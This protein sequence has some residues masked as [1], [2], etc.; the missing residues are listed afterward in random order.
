MKTNIYDV[1]T[2]IGLIVAIIMI[3]WYIIGD[4]PYELAIIVPILFIIYTKLS[5]VEKGVLEN[6]INFKNHVER[7]HKK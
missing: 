4:S 5:S 1:L 6:K 3:I 2:W 7:F